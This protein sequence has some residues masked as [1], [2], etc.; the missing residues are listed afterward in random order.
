MEYRNLGR[1]GVKVSPIALGTGFRAQPEES[2]CIRIIERAVDLGCNFIDSANIYQDGRSEEIVGKALQGKRDDIVL[3]SKVSSPIGDGPNDRGLSRYHIVREVERS[4]RR[5]RT[6]HVD[7]YLLHQPDW[8]TRLEESLRAM[9]DLVRAGK[10]RYLGCSNFPAWNV[11]EGLWVSD[12]N[13]LESFVCI[14]A[15]YNLLTR[16][17]FEP[18]LAPLCKR[19]Q[20]GVMAFSPLAIGLLTGRFRRGRKPPA[21]TPWG[22]GL[23]DFE[24]GITEQGDRVVEKVSEIGNQRGKT[25]A[26]VAIA[27]ILDRDE[28]TTV[29]IGPDQS[30]HVDEA[31]G[32]LGW[33][34]TSEERKILDDLSTPPTRPSFV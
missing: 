11:A 12:A 30:D 8:T 5:L 32:A 25:P 9:D 6:D 17:E 27:W 18:E 33:R 15:P 28:I 26:Q 21:N 31:F 16:E 29:I 3:T 13:Q 7:V 34:L 2:E 24:A 23:Y 1:A 4:I 22:K 20:L 14:Q 10:T 19:F